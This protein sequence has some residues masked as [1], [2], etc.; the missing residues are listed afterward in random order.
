MGFTL[1]GLAWAVS[2]PNSAHVWSSVIDGLIDATLCLDEFSPAEHLELQQCQ[3]L[4]WGVCSG[5]PEQEYS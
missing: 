5:T 3:H 4:A 1:L 2:C